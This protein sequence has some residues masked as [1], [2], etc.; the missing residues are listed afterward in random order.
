MRGRREREEK[1]KNFR[2]NL[3]K[4]RKNFRE[5]RRILEREFL[6]SCISLIKSEK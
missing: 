3:E 2:K 6:N 1:E 5:R 4:K